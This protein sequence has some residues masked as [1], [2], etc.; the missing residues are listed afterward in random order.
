[1]GTLGMGVA[2]FRSEGTSL[3]QLPTGYF[4]LSTQPKELVILHMKPSD[5]GCSWHMVVRA[6]Y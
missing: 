1:V 2:L 4:Y 3:A 5:P 6:R